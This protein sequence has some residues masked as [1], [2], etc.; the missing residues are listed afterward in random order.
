MNN[1]SY[2]SFSYLA[3]LMLMQIEGESYLKGVSSK[4]YRPK[5]FDFS[6]AKGLTQMNEK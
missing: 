5:K 6:A 1:A 3:N 4:G 2:V